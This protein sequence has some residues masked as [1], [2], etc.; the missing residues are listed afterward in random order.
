MKKCEENIE[1]W[2]GQGK[3]NI[4][5]WRDKGLGDVKKMAR[6]LGSIKAMLKRRQVAPRDFEGGQ[7]TLQKHYV[8]SRNKT[9]FLFYF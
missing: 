6:M 9:L 1:G 5:K 7:V 8:T 2:R 4:A 3:G